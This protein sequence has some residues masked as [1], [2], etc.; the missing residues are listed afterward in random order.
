M[1]AHEITED[2]AVAERELAMCLSPHRHP[3]VLL[4]AD[5][6]DVCMPGHPQG[7]ILSAR[8]EV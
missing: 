7:C 5:S 6:R 1:Q 4:P 3:P 8:A 2:T